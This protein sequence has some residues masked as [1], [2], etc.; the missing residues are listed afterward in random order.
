MS[1]ED[2]IIKAI[3]GE[4]YKLN[5]AIRD[6]V[7]ELVETVEDENAD[8]ELEEGEEELAGDVEDD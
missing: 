4:G 5:E 7:D 8:M 6:A 2:D 1:L 3:K